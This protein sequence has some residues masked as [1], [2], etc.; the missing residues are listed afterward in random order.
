MTIHSC[1]CDMF[2]AT[3]NVLE[4]VVDLLLIATRELRRDRESIESCVNSWLMSE[5]GVPMAGSGCGATAAD[6]GR[7]H[8][9][10]KKIGQELE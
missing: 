3:V 7:R 9:L 2:A 5:R 1:F 10:E 4:M 6:F 8:L